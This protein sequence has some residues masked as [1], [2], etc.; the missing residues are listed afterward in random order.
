MGTGKLHEQKQK[1]IIWNIADNFIK[2]MKWQI[3]QQFVFARCLH[4]LKSLSSPFRQLGKTL[5]N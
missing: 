2:I 4:L 3:A 5:S 1:H